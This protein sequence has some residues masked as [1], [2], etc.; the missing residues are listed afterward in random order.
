MKDLVLQVRNISYSYADN[1]PALKN[2]SF[3]LQKGESL[4]I[5]GP[6]GAGKSTLLLHLNGILKGDGDVH[7]F[8]EKITRSNLR[9]IRR[10]VG[11]VFQ[12]PNDQLFMP[13]LYEDISFGLLYLGL[14]PEEI[15]R[16]I[17]VILKKF[18]LE[19]YRDKSPS[20]LSLGE[21][22]KAS[23]ATVLVL[24][25]DILVLDE[26]TGSLDPGSKKLF[27]DLLRNIP[28]A[29]IIATHDI[30]LVW[31]LCSRI[32]FIDKGEIVAEGPVQKI[33]ANRSLLQKHDFDLPRALI[34][35]S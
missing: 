9:Q 4:A 2:V 27:V 20:N 3:S 12:D 24:E 19:E 32:L 25:P 1:S 8:G 18:Y 5:V 15:R 29:K 26:P 13:T 31:D 35:K 21:R 10:K 30:D 33:L 11:V 23:L 17:D 28:K 22:K 7:V 16:K 6:N 34:S 14:D